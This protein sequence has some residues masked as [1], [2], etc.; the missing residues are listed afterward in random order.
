[1]VVEGS[2]Y[3]EVGCGHADKCGRPTYFLSTNDGLIARHAI[4]KMDG[5][6]GGMWSVRYQD[7]V[8][9][10]TT[11]THWDNIEPFLKSNGTDTGDWA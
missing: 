4:S 9:A 10:Q 6:Y 8:D 7:G 2:N 11:Y 3:K 5:V 1:M